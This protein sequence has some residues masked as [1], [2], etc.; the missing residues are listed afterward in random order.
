M[1]LHRPKMGNSNFCRQI[2]SLPVFRLHSRSIPRIT[3]CRIL[4]ISNCWI[5]IVV[6]LWQLLIQHRYVLQIVKYHYFRL[7]LILL[8]NIQDVG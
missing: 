8:P 2:K 3:S 4:L 7:V 1:R 5:I 6:E